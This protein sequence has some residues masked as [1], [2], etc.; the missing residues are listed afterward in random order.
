MFSNELIALSI[1][2][3][4]TLLKSM[5]SIFSMD[6]E[7][8][9]MLKYPPSHNDAIAFSNLAMYCRTASLLETNSDSILEFCK[10]LQNY[11]S[12]SLVTILEN[13]FL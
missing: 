4:E 12:R 10:Q 3:N 9:E 1:V 13:A 2:Q 8:N 5:Q 11:Y 6:Q 7:Y